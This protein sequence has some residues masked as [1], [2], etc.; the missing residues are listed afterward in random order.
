MSNNDP[1]NPGSGQISIPFPTVTS[2]PVT[3]TG[4]WYVFNYQGITVDQGV[5]VDDGAVPVEDKKSNK[6]GCTCIKCKELYPYADPPDP[7]KFVCYACKH[8]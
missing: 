8:F 5:A 7:K 4:G 2:V 3:T 1:N 6:D